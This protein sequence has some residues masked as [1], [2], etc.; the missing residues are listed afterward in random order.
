MTAEPTRPSGGERVALV[1][2]NH[3]G[4]ELLLAGLEAVDRLDYRPLAVV[5]VDNGSADGSAGAVT[6]RFP[7]VHLLREPTNRGVAGGRNIGLRWVL[8][9]LEIGHL[10]FIDN[11]TL[12]E[13]ATVRELVAAAR[14]DP[15]IGLVAPKAFRN[16]R[17][18]HLLSAG[19]L[20]FNPYTGAI[21]DVARGETDRGQHDVAR[22]IQAC[23]GFAFLVRRAV[24]ERIG[25]FDETFN[26]YGWEDVDFSLRAGRAGFRL[27]YAPRAVVYHAGGRAGRGPVP[28][29]ERHKAR[30]LLYLVRRHATPLQWCCFLLLLGFRGAWRVT[31]ELASGNV[32]VVRAWAHGLVGRGT[33]ARGNDHSGRP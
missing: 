23:P 32:D 10:V 29:Y 14:S 26:P 8:D 21:R 16:R 12:V 22:D 25:G 5:V 11:D 2:V 24:F 20:S 7:A 33:G 6:A 3:N 18:P 13:P 1:I 4:R 28:D 17:D 15:R 19:G 9:Q 31:R 27:V 30:N